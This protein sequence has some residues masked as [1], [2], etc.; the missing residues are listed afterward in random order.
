[1]GLAHSAVLEL[2]GITE[3]TNDAAG[4]IIVKAENGELTGILKDNA[5]NMIFELIPVS[6]LGENIDLLRK[7][8]DFLLPKALHR[9]FILMEILMFSRRQETSISSK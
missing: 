9:L 6:S 2:S 7:V 3:N 1:M 8:M 4:G 5:Q